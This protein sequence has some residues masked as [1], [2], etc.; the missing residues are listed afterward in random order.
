MGIFTKEKKTLADMK[1]NE[2]EKV[3]KEAIQ[4]IKIIRKKIEPARMHP[5][6]NEIVKESLQQ[7]I[8]SIAAIRS[9]ISNQINKTDSVKAK[10]ILLAQIELA[11]ASEEKLEIALDPNQILNIKPL[12]EFI[13]FV[14]SAKF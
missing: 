9:V 11:N 10:G 6:N 4:V 1:F 7:M 13:S 8:R 2:L 5:E 14:E 12:N 3:K